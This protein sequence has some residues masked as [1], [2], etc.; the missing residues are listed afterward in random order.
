MRLSFTLFLLSSVHFI[1][2]QILVWEEIQ[3][4]DLI[5]SQLKKENYL[6]ES[7]EVL[8]GK[9]K[10]LLVF[11]TKEE[12]LFDSSFDNIE[13]P[14]KFTNN[15]FKNDEF[16]YVLPIT[17][18]PQKIILTFE[19]AEYKISF[20]QPME[21]LTLPALRPNE[22]RYFEVH[23]E[24]VL[25]Y[26]NIT[27]NERAKGNDAQ[28]VGPNVSDALVIVKTFPSDL[29][30]DI[31]AENG[32]ITKYQKS[33]RGHSIFV[34][35]ESGGSKDFVLKVFNTEFGVTEMN[36]YNVQGK[37]L[38]YYMIKKP[39][40][41]D[42][43]TTLKDPIKDK[44]LSNLEGNWSGSLNDKL[45][46]IKID[47]VSLSNNSA[48]GSVVK[49]GLKYSFRGVVSSTGKKNDYMLNLS[50]NEENLIGS[51]ANFSIDLQFKNNI[52]NGYIIDAK[53]NANDVVLLKT[54][55]PPAIDYNS[56]LQRYNERY[57]NIVGRYAIPSESNVSIRELIINEYDISNN[58]SGFIQLDDNK[59]CRFSSTIVSIRNMS[60][61][62]I[63][64]EASCLTDYV[65][66]QFNINTSGQ[67]ELILQPLN[68]AKIKLVLQEKSQEK[69]N[70]SKVLPVRYNAISNYILR[71][72]SKIIDEYKKGEILVDYTLSFDKTGKKTFIY[73]VNTVSNLDISYMENHLKN[74]TFS[75]PLV[76][77]MKLETFDKGV[78]NLKWI[79]SSKKVVYDEK[80]IEFASIF[81]TNS[82]PYGNYI[83]TLKEVQI[84]EKIFFEQLINK[85]K[86]NGAWSALNSAV[87]PGWGTRKVTY[88]KKNGWGRFT[89]VALP[90]ISAFTS[91]LISR[92]NYNNYRQ[93]DSYLT[94]ELASNYY[95]NANSFRRISLI[96]LGVGLSAYIFDISWVI[97]QGIKNT[98]ASRGIND[99]IKS[100]SILYLRKESLKL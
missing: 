49:D 83:T 99:R 55:M 60:S 4:P 65:Y 14:I 1:S 95:A 66:M 16:I 84:N 71:G 59:I 13:Q 92:N 97:N 8:A 20:S 53:K 40:V 56:N 28:P 85:F 62:D 75:P 37:E 81:K 27:E 15:K 39:L 22:V 9:N 6:N 17:S 3:A 32:V 43:T 38:R 10:S 80:N 36:L 91:E 61:A 7:G 5:F 69:L 100:N 57:S 47:E 63:L 51:M 33:D 68:K 35:A 89:L 34:R 44:N 45:L 26:Y 19:N 41:L 18:Q 30:I 58:I 73:D 94:P 98:K 54:N 74:A 72:G 25:E 42:N 11:K 21:K 87:L 64:P 23:S 67:S 52:L 88:N 29:D 79:T 77:D 70:Y 31:S 2:A 12:I 96:S 78:I 76:G 82:L 46:F 48:A 24:L 50:T 93:T 90:L 86:P